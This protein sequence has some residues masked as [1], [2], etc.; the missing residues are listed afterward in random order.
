M[1]HPRHRL[2][3]ALLTPI[4]LSLMATLGAEA[5][6]DFASLRALL[7]A[8]DSVLSKSIAHLERAGYLKVTKGYVA[9]RPRTWVRSTSRGRKAYA[10]HIRALRE[11]TGDTGV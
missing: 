8:D 5:E 1:A 7:E 9:N 2:D 11:I 4:R 6:Y 10:E 3:D